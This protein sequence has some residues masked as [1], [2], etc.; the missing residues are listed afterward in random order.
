MLEELRESS[1]KLAL[2][3]YWF[4]RTLK[5]EFKQS[6]NIECAL[7]YLDLRLSVSFVVISNAYISMILSKEF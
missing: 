6:S 2:L 5:M 1:K 3:T 7:Q 4:K